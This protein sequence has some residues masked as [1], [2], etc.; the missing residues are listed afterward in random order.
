[1]KIFKGEGMGVLARQA[2]LTLVSLFLLAGVSTPLEA[3]VYLKGQITVDGQAFTGYHTYAYVTCYKKGNWGYYTD[4]CSQWKYTD[5]YGNFS[6]NCD[7]TS[8]N[9]CSSSYKDK[10]WDVCELSASQWGNQTVTSNEKVE[11]S[12]IK[13]ENTLIQNVP[14]RKKDKI[15][16][17]TLTAGSGTTQRNITEG[18][19]VYASQTESP[20]SYTY[21][22]SA[23]NGV[24]RLP[25]LGGSSYNVSSYPDW[26][27]WSHREGGSPYS[28]YPTTTVAVSANA[29][30][31]S[32][33]LNFA[34]KDK[35]IKMNVYAGS[36]RIT[37]G[38][39]VSCSGQGYPYTWS[40]TS[41]V[42]TDGTYALNVT[43][44]CYYCSSYSN[45]W[46]SIYSGYPSTT[47]CLNSSDTTKEGEL[48][49]TVKDKKIRVKLMAGA[50]QLT[51]GMNVSCSQQ[52]DS[53]DYSYVTTPTGAGGT[54]EC[55]AGTGTYGVYAYCTNWDNCPI[56]GY[57]Q[58]KVVFTKDDPAGTT[59]DVTLTYLDNNSWVNGVVADGAGV[60]INLNAHEIFS[61]V[62]ASA[63][64]FSV[65]KKAEITNGSADATQVY[66]Y[67]QANSSGYFEKKVPAGT[68]TLC[69]YPPWDRPDFAQTCQEI[70]TSPNGTVT[71]NIVPTKKTAKIAGCVTNEKGK[72]V[73]AYVNGWAY[74]GSTLQSDYF[75]KE[76]DKKGCFEAN[77]VEKMTYNITANPNTW[78]RSDNGN[79]RGSDKGEDKKDEK[80]EREKL[81]SYTNEGMQSVTATSGAQTVNF[82]VP[83]CGCTMT[84]RFVDGN[85]EVAPI[86]GSV[87]CRQ[88]DA[89]SD[90]YYMSS[91][92]GWASAGMTQ[93]DVEDGQEYQ[94]DAWFWD[95]EHTLDSS[96]SCSCSDG[97]GSCDLGVSNVI[98]NA[99]TGNYIDVDGNTVEI[100]NSY[101][102]VYCIRGNNYRSCETSGTS[103]SCDLSEGDWTCGYW[104]NPN[105]GFASASMGTTSNLVSITSSGSVR[106]DLT[107]YATASCLARV[108]NF[109]DSP[110]KDAWVEC[111]PYSASQEGSNDYQRWYGCGWGHTD[112][113]GEAIVNVG[114]NAEGVTYYCN[115]Y[116]PYSWRTNTNSPR[117][118]SVVVKRDEVAE[119][120]LA[121]AQPEGRA[122][123]HV[124]EGEG[125]GSSQSL[126]KARGVVKATPRI[127]GLLNAEET[128]ASAPCAFAT[129]DFFSPTR[130]ELEA[131]TDENCMAE[132]PC[133]PEAV[134]YAVAYNNVSNALYTSK[135]TET[136][137]TT[138][139]PTT[140][141]TIDFIA[142]I[143]EGVSQTITDAATQS[144]T[145]EL[146][147]RTSVIFPAGSLGE[148]GDVVTCSMDCIL[149]PFTSN[150]IPINFCSYYTQCLN[151]EGVAIHELRSD[152]TFKLIYNQEHLEDNL[153]L[154]EDDIHCTYFD[155]AEGR[156]N[157]I[158]TAVL[159]REENFVTFT[160]NHLTDFALVGNG[161]LGGIQGE[162]LGPIGKEKAS[163][164]INGGSNIGDPAS[165][166][167]GGGQSPAAGGCSLNQGPSQSALPWL[168]IMM[169]FF[170]FVIPA[171][172]SRHRH[173]GEL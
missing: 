77:A 76:T 83:N 125:P 124:L 132:F 157:H 53:W 19:T 86:N 165:P 168:I 90:E 108:T 7:D 65:L 143:P 29:T 133:D 169:A 91:H 74:N 71:L 128:A 170:V 158:H 166:S 39:N 84:V 106:K 161:Y 9:C 145:L 60:S 49:Y 23:T 94:C 150:K 3:H 100:T 52:G 15:I 127:K 1:M 98:E 30:T 64:R 58:G 17:V 154:E 137:C 110:N 126:G 28:G 73:S 144:L 105:S 140:D 21:I 111:C 25:V 148:S 151:S 114:T 66:A 26:S 10:E 79:G 93:M 18:M 97:V 61:S 8:Y 27:Y 107:L 167:S 54:Y 115:A 112:E 11:L 123:I 70:T 139:S 4:S 120:D 35:K 6:F 32:A 109:D 146:A 57:P 63:T 85:D 121:Y 136:A 38:I 155:T 68:Y 102:N 46:P 48:F 162:N 80:E 31:V 172:L 130:G 103:Y 72:G 101:I 87:S 55:P 78:Y 20:W 22:T 88:A 131:L 67:T 116:M 152:A 160:V 12:A 36:S 149:T 171:V 34:L 33:T 47:V 89:D 51:S 45:T 92:W 134:W 56:S 59:A 14:L 122:V 2:V 117:E 104:V 153:G 147:D 16:E 24:Y 42:S 129:V 99:V 37:N 41:R 119:C 40:S 163:G 62:N 96:A 156:Y 50:R 81:C 95:N 69:V 5:Y 141:V 13:C 138:E 75:W 142:S 44:G 113:E 118:C 135:A 43:E 164:G 82:T 173:P 159:D